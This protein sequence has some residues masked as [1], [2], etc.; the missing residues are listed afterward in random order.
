M[1]LIQSTQPKGMKASGAWNDKV[2]NDSSSEE[3]DDIPSPK[4]ESKHT[5][6][7]NRLNYDALYIS[8]F[9]KH[10]LKKSRR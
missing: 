5:W 9:R 3:L 8:S 10:L 2:G 4:V 6:Y 1:T 7:Y